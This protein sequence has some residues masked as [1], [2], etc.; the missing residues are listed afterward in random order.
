[1]P[2]RISNRHKFFALGTYKAIMLNCGTGP[3]LTLKQTFIK[4]GLVR[5]LFFQLIM[6][7]GRADNHQFSQAQ[8][9]IKISLKLEINKDVK[10]WA[11]VL[12]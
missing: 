6:D 8:M 1:M 5:D 3:V 12:S 7:L 2:C 11:G 9:F 4:S 10:C